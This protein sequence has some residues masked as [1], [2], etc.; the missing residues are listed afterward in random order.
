MLEDDQKCLAS[1]QKDQD[2]LQIWIGKWW[3]TMWK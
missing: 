1:I 2:K 3:K